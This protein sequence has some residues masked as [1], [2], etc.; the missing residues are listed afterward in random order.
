MKIKIVSTFS[1]K[2]YEEYGKHFV[3]SCKKFISKKI[4]IRLYVDNISL[5]NEENIQIL[6]LEQSVP[7]LT[8]FK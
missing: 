6:K 1:D 8:E 5:A 4:D 7:A 3:E 2:G